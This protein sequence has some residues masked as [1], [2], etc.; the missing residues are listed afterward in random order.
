MDAIR[1]LVQ[2]TLKEYG[3]VILVTDLSR[4]GQIDWERFC[5]VLPVWEAVHD[6]RQIIFLLEEGISYTGEIPSMTLSH[7]DAEK[8]CKLYLTYEF[9]DRFTLFSGSVQYGNIFCYVD[10]GILTEGEA[11]RAI[12]D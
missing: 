2:N 5:T 4:Q 11:V 1:D 7:E 6:T 10:T 12:L 9:S 3:R 8:L